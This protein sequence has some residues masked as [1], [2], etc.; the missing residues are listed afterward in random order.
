MAQF[1][2]SQ[3]IAAGAT[4]D[5][6]DGYN[7][8]NTPGPGMIKVNH[9][10]TAVGLVASIYATD[11]QVMQEGPVPSGGT[12]GVTPSDFNVPPIIEPVEGGK[13]LSIRY[14]NPTGGAITVDGAI[15]F[16]PGGRGGGG[17]GPRRRRR[18]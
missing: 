2:W 10:A 15:D 7:Y 5:P 17:G 12:A 1:P 16:A 18:K 8:Q 14:R 6:L 4:F 3:S 13:R 11:R 9:R